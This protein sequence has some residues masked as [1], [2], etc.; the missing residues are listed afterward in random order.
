MNV[1]RWIK[2]QREARGWS[3]S[4]LAE[5]VMVHKNTIYNWEGGET[6]PGPLYM[7][8]LAAVFNTHKIQKED[9]D[10]H[11]ERKDPRDG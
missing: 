3:Q 7:E 1:G 2:E 9:Q 5:L 6:E 8:K 10:E 11:A 4:Q